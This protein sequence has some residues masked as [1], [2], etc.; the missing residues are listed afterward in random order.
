MALCERLHWEIRS[1]Q[2]VS[3]PPTPVTLGPTHPLP[4]VWGLVMAPITASVARVAF[5]G[6]D[7]NHWSSTWRTMPQKGSRAWVAGEVP[8]PSS[9]HTHLGNG[10]CE[11]LVVLGELGSQGA[12]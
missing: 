2:A 4:G 12:P 5:R 3:P 6:S 9:G 11:D 7:S 10:G 1:P 8:G